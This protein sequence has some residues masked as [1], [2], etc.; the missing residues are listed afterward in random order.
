MAIQM[1]CKA[2][3]I[4]EEIEPSLMRIKNIYQHEYHPPS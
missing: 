1:Q 3:L 4:V 2:T